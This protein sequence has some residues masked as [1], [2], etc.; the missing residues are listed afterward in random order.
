L[1]NYRLLS[2]IQSRL[3]YEMNRTDLLRQLRAHK[4]FDAREG[5]MLERITDF[6]IDN[7]T[8]FDKNLKVGHLTGSAWIVDWDRTHALLTHHARLGLWLQLGGHVEDDPDMLNAAWREAREESGLNCVRP[9]S[10]HIF[11]VD[12][13]EIPATPEAPAHT[14]YDIRFLFEADRSAEL[15]ATAESKALRWIGLEEITD[16]TREESVLRMVRKIFAA[17]MSSR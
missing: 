2:A 17:E 13:H 9:V 1:A 5:G 14:H 4:P 11:D 3:K 15:A 16:V 8:C 6:V 12:V 10:S 7:E